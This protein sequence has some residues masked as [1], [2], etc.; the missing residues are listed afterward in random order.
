M[1]EDEEMGVLI[2]GEAA[3]GVLWP[4]IQDRE[5]ASASRVPAVLLNLLVCSACY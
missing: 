5:M 4:R 1:R 2:V 3:D